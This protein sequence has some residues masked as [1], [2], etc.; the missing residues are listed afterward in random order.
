MKK[1]NI[2]Q[3]SLQELAEKVIEKEDFWK[4][5][6]ILPELNPVKDMIYELSIPSEFE[7]EEAR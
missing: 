1:T 3:K 5:C 4:D 2:C 6:K 7:L